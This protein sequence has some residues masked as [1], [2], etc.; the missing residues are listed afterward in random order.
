MR[1][2]REDEALGAVA[3]E[4]LRILEPLRS[5]RSLQLVEADVEIPF[6]RTVTRRVSAGRG[7][8][9]SEVSLLADDIRVSAASDIGWLRISITENRAP[10]VR[11]ERA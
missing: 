7:G 5:G 11:V 3:D 1:L 9:R 6:A 4:V 2:R 10:T 8:G